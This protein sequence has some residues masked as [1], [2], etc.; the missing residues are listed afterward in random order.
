MGGLGLG[1]DIAMDNYT[2][3]N[4]SPS[5][6][7]K[8]NNSWRRRKIGLEVSGFD[9]GGQVHFATGKSTEE[10]VEEVKDNVF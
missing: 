5:G 1:F 7:L 6:S 3:D 10:H 4:Y 9:V 2:N 8:E